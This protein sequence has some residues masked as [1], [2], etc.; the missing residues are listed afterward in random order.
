[1]RNQDSVGMFSPIRSIRVHRWVHALLLLAC[2]AILVALFVRTP[3]KKELPRVLIIG[4]SISMEYTPMVAAL[5]AKQ[6]TVVHNP[7]NGGPTIRGMREVEGYLGD[8]KWDVIH[9]N[10]G[11]WDMYGW[12]YEKADR[13]PEEYE[14]RLE[15]LVH[16]LEQTGARLIWATSTP[17][18]PEEEKD[19]GVLVDPATERL[20]LE[21]AAQV[22]ARHQIQVD[23]LHAFME[24]VRAQYALSD[25]NVHFT[26]EGYELL[27]EQVARSIE[28]ALS[29][30]GSM[31]S[32]CETH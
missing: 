27:A 15:A 21:A 32:A 23:D 14:R 12:K 3:G 28:S 7:G 10:W 25:N 30:G 22:M 19:S 11:L 31:G 8:E 17:I 20:Y 5:L 6:A 9:F 29:G 4:D 16:R 13:S 1:M 2:T 26:R 24:P 18:C